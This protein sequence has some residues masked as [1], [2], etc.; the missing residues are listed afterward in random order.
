MVDVQDSTNLLFSH[1]YSCNAI[2][3]HFT[4][5]REGPQSYWVPTCDIIGCQW[6]SQDSY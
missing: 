3:I 5:W 6:E 2:I 4:V 1:L